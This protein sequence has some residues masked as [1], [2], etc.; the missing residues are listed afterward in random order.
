[1]NYKISDKDRLYWSVYTGDD[2]FYAAFLTVMMAVPMI[3]D[4]V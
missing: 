1:M 3:I 4:S 2:R